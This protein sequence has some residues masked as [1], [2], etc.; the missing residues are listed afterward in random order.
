MSTLL[1]LLMMMMKMM[2]RRFLLACPASEL[3]LP[4]V[5]ERGRQFARPSVA[6]CTS[7]LK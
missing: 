6:A 2:M 5:G 4:G 3:V 7:N 1:L